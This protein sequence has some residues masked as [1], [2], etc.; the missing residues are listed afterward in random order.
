M[1]FPQ[2]LQWGLHI[3]VVHRKR[4]YPWPAQR[5]TAFGLESKQHC[6][7]SFDAIL[8]KSDGTL[9][10]IAT[11]QAVRSELL[12]YLLCTASGSGI[13]LWCHSHLF[14]P[15]YMPLS[16][17]HLLIPTFINMCISVSLTLPI[18]W[19][20]QLALFRK[21]TKEDTKSIIC[22]SQFILG[23]SILTG[24]IMLTLPII[25]LVGIGLGL[26]VESARVMRDV[27]RIFIAFCTIPS[28]IAGLAL[29][30]SGALVRRRNIKTAVD[31]LG[32]DPVAALD[33]KTV[34]ELHYL[35]EV[36]LKKGKIDVAD[37]I[38]THLLRR[39]ENSTDV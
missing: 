34:D 25:Q 16:D 20:R 11:P 22:S 39:V 12:T 9:T 3:A 17:L 15:V 19:R 38:S 33:S 31:F 7:E 5:T 24:A 35:I 14:W 18:L 13:F 37:R 4:Y 36:A 21:A 30:S 28:S 10:T 6:I 8:T 23:V 32:S 2:I 27:F 1:L 29:I 26:S